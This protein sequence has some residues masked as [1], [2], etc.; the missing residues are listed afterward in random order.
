MPTKTKHQFPDKNTVFKLNNVEKLTQQEIKDAD[1]VY[2]QI[3]LQHS[4]KENDKYWKSNGLV[5]SSSHSKL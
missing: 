3:Y 5:G 4:R 1:D 2:M